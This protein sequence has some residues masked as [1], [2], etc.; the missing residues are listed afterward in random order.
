MRPAAQFHRVISARAVPVA[1]SDG[2][3]A[4][5]LAVFLAEERHRAR[6]DSLVRAHQP[7]HDLVVRADFGVHLRLDGG[8]LGRIERFRMREIEA[9]PLLRDQR[10]F[11]CHVI[12]KMV[13]QRGMD[14]MRRRVVRAD[15]I[16]AFDIDA[17]VNGI[18]HRYAAAAH[19]PV[20][21]VKAAERFRRVFDFD[22]QAMIAGNRP[23]IAAL[24]AALAI[25]RRLV[26]QH[27][28][29]LAAIGRG[30]FPAIDH[31]RDDPTLAF[32]GRV[33]CKFR[34]A[35][36]LGDVEPDLAVGCC[37][38]TLPR[39]TCRR[40]LLCHGGVESVAVH[41]DTAI[42][43][44]ILGQI[45]GKAIGVVELERGFARQAV[46]FGK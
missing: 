19:L 7:G 42:A 41:A 23:G 11:L 28:D 10:A 1:R 26:G 9:Q 4:H 22:R 20:M 3:H 35:F 32:R 25:E 8:D 16:A 18:T 45:I 46:A 44:G 15:R 5:F 13:P 43:Q 12:A 36:A 33:A 27:R 38:R 24:S 2:K 31:E 21:R 30:H 14:Q 34:C 40:F 29:V 6:I 39:G 17:E 37:A